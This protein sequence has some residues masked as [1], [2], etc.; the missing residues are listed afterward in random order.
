MNA[1]TIRYQA[2]TYS[3]ERTVEAEDSEQAIAIVRGWV[4]RQMSLPMYFES[5]DVVSERAPGLET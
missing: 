5:Y 2:G 1:Y 4:R 3:G